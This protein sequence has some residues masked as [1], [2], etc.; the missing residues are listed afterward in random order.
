MG[1]LRPSHLMALFGHYGD[2]FGKSGQRAIVV[3]EDPRRRKGSLKVLN[4]LLY[5]CSFGRWSAC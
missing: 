4:D 3:L 5:Q 1:R 2:A